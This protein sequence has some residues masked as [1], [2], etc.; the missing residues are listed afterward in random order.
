MP[1]IRVKRGRRERERREIEANG[2]RAVIVAGIVL[3]VIGAGLAWLWH[4]LRGR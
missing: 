2:D 3:T 1:K 4:L